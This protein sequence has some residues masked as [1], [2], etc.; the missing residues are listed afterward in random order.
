MLTY[1]FNEVGV[2]LYEQVYK[3][4]KNDIIKGSL[5]P[6]EKLPSKGHL[7]ITMELVPLRYRMHM[8]S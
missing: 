3:S 2:P 1:V 7:Q 4:I 6:G 5:K 8:T